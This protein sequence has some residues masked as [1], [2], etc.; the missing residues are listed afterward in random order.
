MLLPGVSEEIADNFNAS[1]TRQEQ[2]ERQRGFMFLRIYHLKHGAMTIYGKAE[3][4]TRLILTRERERYLTMV[5]RR[6][7]R[8][9]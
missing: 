5:T 8:R 9:Y 2:L 7:G 3:A 6:R 4:F 1:E